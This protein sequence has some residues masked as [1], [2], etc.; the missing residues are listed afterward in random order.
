VKPGALTTPCDLA[1]FFGPYEKRSDVRVMAEGAREMNFLREYAPLLGPQSPV[2]ARVR[3]S[4]DRAGPKSCYAW[5]L[6]PLCYIVEALCRAGHHADRRLKPAVNALLGAQRK[7]G[8]W[9]RCL[10]GDVACTIPAVRALG[11]HPGLRDGRGAK[12]ALGYL[13]AAQSGEAGRKAQGRL[14]GARLFAAL[15]AVAR[16][17]L[18]VAREV[19]GE[20]LRTVAPHQRA[21]GSFGTPH[22]AA[23]A[24]VVVAAC[25]RLEKKPG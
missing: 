5:G 18:P 9:C 23:R 3:S 24:A 8:G 20:A 4:L 7:S 15:E 25:R 21:N 22:P 11:T 16:F 19:I 14:R 6:V 10:G 17:D 13:R 12:A 2:R 1:G